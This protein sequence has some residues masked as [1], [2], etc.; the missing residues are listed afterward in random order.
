MSILKK[1]HNAIYDIRLLNLSEKELHVV[2][3]VSALDTY[4]NGRVLSEILDLPETEINQ[5][6]LNL[7]INNI[8][9]EYTSGQTI[10]F[11]SEAIKK[12]R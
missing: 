1:T 5:M 2:K 4:I 6:I 12:H 3:V 11:S 7:Q 8:I 10:V 9:Q